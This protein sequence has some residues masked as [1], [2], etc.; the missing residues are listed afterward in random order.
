MWRWRALRLKADS[1]VGIAD[2]CTGQ[3]TEVVA[4]ST[5]G[6]ATSGTAIRQWQLGAQVVHH[7]VDPATGLPAKQMWRTVSTTAAS[8]VEANTA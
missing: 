5:G 8:C 7:I 1:R 4:I 3:A 2:K 6:L